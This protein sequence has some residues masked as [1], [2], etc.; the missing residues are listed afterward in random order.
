ML[1]LILEPTQNNAH[2]NID[3]FGIHQNKLYTYQHVTMRK[4]G[5]QCAPP[6]LNAC[7]AKAVDLIRISLA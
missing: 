7:P 3:A 6:D 1:R 2:E 5:L 4:A